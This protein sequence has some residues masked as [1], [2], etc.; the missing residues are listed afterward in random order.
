M[1]VFPAADHF[2]T[3][4]TLRFA[5]QN[6]RQ[7]HI[8][9]ICP[10]CLPQYKHIR[11]NRII[12]ECSVREVRYCVD[13]SGELRQLGPRPR[14]AALGLRSPLSGRASARHGGMHL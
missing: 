7:D 8:R 14:D 10:T 12:S 13:L 1:H 2:D 6:A 3:N 9:E 4:L 5:Y 11:R